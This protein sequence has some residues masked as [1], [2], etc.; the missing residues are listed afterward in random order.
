MKSDLPGAYL[1]TQL[2]GIMLESR[3]PTACVLG[4]INL[5]QKPGP[6]DFLKVG[7]LNSGIFSVIADGPFGLDFDSGQRDGSRLS[8]W[9]P[10][11]KTDRQITARG[12]R[13]F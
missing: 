9:Q 2:L 7:A 6:S 8:C 12:I 1:V 3:S 10:V 4:A 5:S 13:I 11:A